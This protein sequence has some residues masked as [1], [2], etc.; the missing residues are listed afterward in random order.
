M[1]GPLGSRYPVI[2]PGAGQ[3]ALR[4][5]LRVDPALDRVAAQPHVLLPDRERLA[6]RD[7][8]LLPDEI[9]ARH[10][11]GDGVLD[12]DPGVHL[13][14]VVVA[15]SREETLD[16]PRRAIARGSRGVDRDLPDP[17]A[18]SLV[19]GRRRRLLDQLLVAALNRA[20]ALAE[21]DHVAVR[22][23][24]HLHLHMPRILEIALD[25]DPA[26]GEVL[27]ALPPGGFERALGLVRRLDQL[28]PLAAT[29]GRRLD[30][31][32]V[33]DLARRV[34]APPPPTRPAPSSPG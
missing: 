20:V 23:R 28:H 34:R 21:M 9:D 10:L 27:L 22:V 14:E 13:H 17:L 25:V 16:R 1:P 3:E 18:Q 29:A 19:H 6:G 24:E 26:V 12:L 33:A 31:Q 11:L 4:H 5:V 30:D 8:H 32:R 15:G 2:R 7:E